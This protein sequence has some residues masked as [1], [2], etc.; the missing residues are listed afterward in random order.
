MVLHSG[1]ARVLVIGLP[2]AGT[3]LLKGMLVLMGLSD[4]CAALNT[5][6]LCYL[7]GKKLPWRGSIRNGSGSR[8]L[9]GVD[10]P[11]YVAAAAW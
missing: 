7:H 10:S 8:L 2:K 4:S 9:I 3:N 6:A 11:K 5:G 1:L